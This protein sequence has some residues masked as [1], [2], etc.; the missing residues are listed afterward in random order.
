MSAGLLFSL[1]FEAGIESGTRFSLRYL[2]D[3]AV[4]PRNFPK[5]V[6]ILVILGTAAVVFTL[7]CVLA[8]YLWAKLGA[9]VL[10]DLRRDLFAHVQTLSADFF[11]RRTSGDVLSCFIADA[12]E[13]ESFLVSVV[14]YAVL[15]VTGAILSS[16]LM[17]TIHPALAA[18]SMMGVTASLALPRLL[19]DRALR[20][21]LEA[22]RQEGRLSST[23]QEGLQSYSLIRV[24]GL[25]REVSR[26]FRQDS[27]K[28]M[29]LSVRAGFLA[30]LVQR[31]PAISFFLMCLVIFGAS[32]A[33]AIRG[34]LSIGEVVSFQVLVLGLSNAIANLT[35]VTPLVLSASASVERLNEIYRERPAIRD[36]DNARH[37]DTFER[38]IT[39]EQV[40]FTYVSS[41][42]ARD[43]TL[44]DVSLSIDKGDFVVFVGPNG[45]GK[46]SLFH[47]LVRLY[48]PDAGRITV[49]G[50]D[51]RDLRLSSLRSLIGFVSQE[52]I[53]FDLSIRDNVRMGRLDAR[54][55]EI[56]HA[57]DAAEVG[58]H[59]RRLPRGLE[60]V[61]GERGAKLS[62]GERQRL[63]LARALVRS[64]EILVLDEATSA[65]DPV[66]EADLLSTIRRLSAERRMTVLAATHRL[67]VAP[68]ATR[69]IVMH[70]GRIE[71]DGKHEELLE[72]QGTYASL[73]A[74]AVAA[75]SPRRRWSR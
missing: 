57:L 25:E 67:H 23:I 74:S 48:D 36:R 42:S 14:P 30:Y 35:W 5:L 28:L 7:L 9:R 40:S 43:R 4:I 72:Q 19:T 26:R 11:A 49:D 75:T 61:V 44:D 53:L 34:R 39:F 63:A 46:T 6:I 64:P 54:D 13:I 65:L 68:I 45:S 31:L 18:A 20:A 58:D 33:L 51:L 12:N 41:S 17:A 24:F 69:V 16:S 70:E 8:D 59:V 73:W 62:G 52:T 47:L 71:S 21:S 29:D 32:S 2:I 37:L 15:G 1:L 27:S 56:W 38:R 10:N 55:D 66:H 50:I 22:Q 60:T 3:E